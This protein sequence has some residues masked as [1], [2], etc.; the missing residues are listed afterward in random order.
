[1]AK[2]YIF[3]PRISTEKYSFINKLFCIFYRI[4]D[5]LE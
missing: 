3:S 5:L 1:L 2:L 4:V